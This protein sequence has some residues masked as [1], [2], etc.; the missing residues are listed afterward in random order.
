MTPQTFD[1]GQ[2]ECKGCPLVTQSGIPKMSLDVRFWLCGR[3][4]LVSLYF[5]GDFG[6]GIG[7]AQTLAARAAAKWLFKGR[8]ELAWQRRT[9]N[10]LQTT[11]R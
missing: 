8:R 5:S 6:L 3:H 4:R 1:A 11:S 2:L 7:A 10:W 9:K